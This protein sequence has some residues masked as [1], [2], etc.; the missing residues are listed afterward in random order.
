M[1][2]KVF[3][4]TL[5]PR[6]RAIFRTHHMNTSFLS[7]QINTLGVIFPVQTPIYSVSVCV[8]VFVCVCK[9]VEGSQHSDA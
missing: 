4:T 7:Y 1:I 8:C 5:G 6:N 9:G 2:T 3:L